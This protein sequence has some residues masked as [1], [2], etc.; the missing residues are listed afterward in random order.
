M[1]CR[2]GRPFVLAG[3][4]ACA[5][6]VPTLLAAQTAPAAT[7]Q[8]RQLG[9]IVVTGE[10]RE[11]R[12]Q[13]APLSITAIQGDALRE[14]NINQL[15]DLDGY[16]PGLTIAKSEGAERIITIRGIGYE[17]A[18]NPNSQPGVAFHIDGVYIANV[19]ALNQDLLDVDRIEVLRGP[20][21]TVFGETSTGG[22]ID[23][24]T[25]KPV[26]GEASAVAQV[27]GGTHSYVKANAAV[28][29]PVSDTIAARASI[30]YLRHGPYGEATAV[31]GRG[32][33]G[34]EDASN[35]GVR[36]SLIWTPTDRFTALLAGQ[37]FFADHSAALQK[38]I[39]DRDPRARHVTQD[40]PGIFNVQTK[41]AYLTL[42]QQIGDVATLKSVT[43]YQTL[44]KHQTS[45]NDRLASPF[46]FDDIT[47]WQDKSRTFTQELSLASPAGGRLDWD[48]GAFY[49]RQHAIQNIFETTI[50]A[51]SALV[52][53]D[54]TGVKFQTD[55]PYQ[56]TSIAG[57]GQATYR[58]TD[59]LS[60]VGGLRYSWDKVTAQPVQYF[61]AQAPRASTSG[62][63]TG[64]LGA[65][66][67]LAPDT[68]VYATAS[69]GYKPTGVSF[70]STAPFAPGSFAS[71]PAFVP[72][73]YRK[74]TVWAAEIG[75][76]SDFFDHLLRLN[77]AG[78]Y[79]WYRDFQFTAEDPV[80]FAGGTDNIPHARIYGA[81]VEGS[82]LPMRGLRFDGTLS[83]GRGRFT[84][85]LLTIDA[86]TAAQVRGATYAAIGYPAA[87]YYDAR[88]ERA[89]ADAR[90]DVDG[91]RIPKLPGTRAQGTATYD[92]HMA[93]GTVTLRAEIVYR[94]AFNYRIFAVSTFDRVPAYT[95]Y[96][97]FVRYRPDAGPWSVSVSAQNLTDRNGINSKF[98][99]PYGSGST[100]VEYI[101]PREIFGTVSFK[102]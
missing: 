90:Q 67:R 23:V 24:V 52:L 77:V 65:E 36:G 66:Y 83:L 15:V 35:V 86:Q 69:R 16:V 32:R 31:P 91:N 37:M 93:G 101:D 63:L 12:I 5:L 57:Y 21:G 75:T 59:R 7:D 92:W 28:N 18:Q 39:D 50:P 100:S 62:A 61:A 70:V 76:K 68:M 3:V 79:Y 74:E 54:G 82:L 17:T 95:I 85:H 30:Q 43:A 84:S 45:D 64:K 14:R 10:K 56:H 22:A 46:F 81:E 99:D 6:C 42:A 94:G 58:A 11:T 27:S 29:I 33:Y 38:E 87:F 13:T 102:F 89:V 25:R 2:A 47:L 9:D 49:L 41:M 1:S 71:G 96:N 55:S 26:I 19:I 20:Q 60:L 72:P 88:V 73:T 98:A 8:A 40:Y 78:Y 51:A 53:P 34:L 4:A 48:A 80:P 97:A 44:N